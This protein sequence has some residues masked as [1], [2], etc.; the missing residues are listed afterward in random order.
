M[1]LQAHWDQKSCGVIHSF[2]GPCL[3]SVFIY[4]V[5]VV[6]STLRN[7]NDFYDQL[8]KEGFDMHYTVPHYYKRFQ[9]TGGSCP[10]TCCAGWQIQI[11]PASLKKYSR[12]KGPIGSRLKNEID[13][14][15]QCFRQYDGKCAFLNEKGLCDLY[16]EG[17]GK[18]AFCRTCRTYPRHIEEFE[19]LR[20]ISLSLSCPAA[21]ELILGSEEPVRFLEADDPAKE[22]SYPEFDF[23]LF[24]K[25]M[26]ARALIFRILQNREH[27]FRLRAAI[28][29][30]LAH[31][32]QERIDKNALFDADRLLERYSAPSVWG[33]FERRLHMLDSEISHTRLS[34]QTTGNLFVILNQLEVLRPEWKARLRSARDTLSDPS[35][36]PGTVPAEFQAVFPDVIAEQLMVYFV[37][38]Y[39]CG[40]VYSG[41][42]YG[43]MKFALACTLLI[44]ELARA[45]WIKDPAGISSADVLDI[46]QKFSRETEHS[47]FNKYRM[48]KMLG[49]EERFGLERLFSVL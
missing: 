44:R 23:F 24:T 42:A 31:D 11:D 33:W 25:L 32:L 34:L 36:S 3:C 35:A 15:E 17:G 41:N 21:A 30:A 14:N 8:W 29:L 2:F 40:A 9:C 43:K 38:T 12:T 49:D 27:P 28:C 26:D 6:F 46:A 48:E 37:F 19:G 13:W 45:E 22:E 1:C 7:Y 10:D 39:F 16:L 4:Y 47:D 20:E 5:T 18:Q